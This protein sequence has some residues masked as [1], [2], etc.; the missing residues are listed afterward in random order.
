MGPKSCEVP[1][2]FKR[3]HL[4]LHPTPFSSSS[5]GPYLAQQDGGG[6]DD[7]M[8]VLLG[9]PRRN[10]NLG[11]ACCFISGARSAATMEANKPQGVWLNQRAYCD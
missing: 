7:Y 6:M 3:F 4:L 9:H 8:R 5:C 2:M 10:M 1:L 11:L